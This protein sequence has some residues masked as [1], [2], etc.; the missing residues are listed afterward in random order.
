MGCG[1]AA[2]REKI[3]KIA[4][5]AKDRVRQALNL[6]QEPPLKSKPAETPSSSPKGFTPSPTASEK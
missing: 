1:C 5:K 2:R 6:D 3:R 4:Q